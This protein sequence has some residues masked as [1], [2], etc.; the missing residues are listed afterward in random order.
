MLPHKV[1]AE[2]AMVLLVFPMVVYLAAGVDV[3]GK[4]AKVCAFLGIASYSIYVIHEPLGALIEAGLRSEGI[5]PWGKP[6]YWVL[7][8]AFI[9][10][11]SWSLDRYYDAPAR[12]WL[13][14][15]LTEF[16]KQASS[17]EIQTEESLISCAKTTR[18][19]STVVTTT[20]RIP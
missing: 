17:G 15:K 14:D 11:L 19:P 2:F 6:V 16:S 20:S 10:A 3:T 1:G 12:R 4:T 5:D 13:K 9:L 8:L 18:C 7:F